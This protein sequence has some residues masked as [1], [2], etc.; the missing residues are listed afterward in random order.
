MSERIPS[1]MTCYRCRWS[2]HAI[3]NDFDSILTCSLTERPATKLCDRFE[4]EP[5]TE[6]PEH[7]GAE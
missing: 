2:C 7:A 6:E 1:P 5:G 3:V 4:Y